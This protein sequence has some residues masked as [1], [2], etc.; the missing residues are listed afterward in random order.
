[1]NP[2]VIFRHANAFRALVASSAL[3]TDIIFGCTGGA[4]DAQLAELR[5]QAKAKH[6]GQQPQQQKPAPQKR[7]APVSPVPAAVPEQPVTGGAGEARPTKLVKRTQP[8]PGAPTPTPPSSSALPPPTEAPAQPAASPQDAAAEAGPEEPGTTAAAAA[9]PQ[10][11]PEP[12]AAPQTAAPSPE[13]PS[14]PPPAEAQ[15]GMAPHP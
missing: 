9:A 13:P 10:E 15:T 5:A 7:K 1:M 8:E 2:T 14:I 4:V 6:D 3:L 11:Q 12:A